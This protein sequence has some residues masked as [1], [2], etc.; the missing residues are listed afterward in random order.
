VL[1]VPSTLVPEASTL[2]L[3]PRHPRASRRRLW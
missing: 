2:L 3:N 1:R